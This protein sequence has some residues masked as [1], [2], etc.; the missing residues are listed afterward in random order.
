MM[1]QKLLVCV[2]FVWA[3]IAGGS[4]ASA[5]Q[6]ATQGQPVQVEADSLEISQQKGEAVFEGHVKVSQ[7]AIQLRAEKVTVFYTA[8]AFAVDNGEAQM[9]DVPPV[10]GGIKQIVAENNVEI[11]YNKDK[12]TG[13]TAVYNLQDNQIKLVGNVVLVRD[14]NT[15]SGNMLTYNLKTGQMK[16]DGG[17][18]QQR[19]RA[20][21]VPEAK[22]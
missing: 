10:A 15:V 11:V 14:G 20:R 9:P 2:G 19:V 21:F 7:N 8:R 18:Q 5:Q 4:V 1:W 17:K 13:K 6:V 16:L 22:Q 3:G 12:A